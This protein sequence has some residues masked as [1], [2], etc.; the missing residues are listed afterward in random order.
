MVSDIEI[1]RIASR[2][3]REGV[4]SKAGAGGVV[5]V[6]QFFFFQAEDGI[7]DLTVT[8][9]QTCALPVCKN[10]NDY[11]SAYATKLRADQMAAKAEFAVLSSNHFP[12]DIRQLHLHQGV[13]V[14]CPADRKSVV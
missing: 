10:R 6:C 9:V 11:K 12:G 13:I 1:C 3:R 14:A 4:E 2:C 7:R 5:D 8:G